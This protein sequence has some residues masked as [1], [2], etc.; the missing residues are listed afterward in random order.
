[1]FVNNIMYNWK[2]YDMHCMICFY[3]NRKEEMKKNGL[4]LKERLDNNLV[5]DEKNINRVINN[6][7]FY[8]S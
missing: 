1:M 6:L 7:K 5:V 8:L 3:S 4:I 2:A